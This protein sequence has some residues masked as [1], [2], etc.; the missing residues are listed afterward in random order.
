MLMTRITSWS[1]FCSAFMFCAVAS[2]QTVQAPFNT[3]YSV[4]D[5]GTPPGVPR[6]LGGLTFLDSDTLLIGGRSKRSTSPAMQ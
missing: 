5:L 1:F 2:G 4:I 3:D 6:S